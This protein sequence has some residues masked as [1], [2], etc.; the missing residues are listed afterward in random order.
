MRGARERDKCEMKKRVGRGRAMKA[1]KAVRRER[2][3][4]KVCKVFLGG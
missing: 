3:V 4:W 2:K 1:V